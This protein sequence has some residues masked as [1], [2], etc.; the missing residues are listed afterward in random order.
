MICLKISELFLLFSCKDSVLSLYV[1]LLL[2]YREGM[3]A[4]KFTRNEEIT[5]QNA[6]II[7]NPITEM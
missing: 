5:F 4:F 1:H 2:G 7:L 3:H 6:F